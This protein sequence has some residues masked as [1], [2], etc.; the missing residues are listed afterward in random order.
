MK[1]FLKW[2]VIADC[3]KTLILVELK[4]GFYLF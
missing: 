1:K 3:I 4:L 2:F